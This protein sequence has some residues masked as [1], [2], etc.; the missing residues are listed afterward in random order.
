MLWRVK[1]LCLKCTIISCVTSLAGH[2]G[3]LKEKP[4]LI[5]GLWNY[6]Y[7]TL[8]MPGTTMPVPR[9]KETKGTGEI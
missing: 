9:K 2:V 1:F 8:E 7:V 6:S 5:L 4:L 3:Q